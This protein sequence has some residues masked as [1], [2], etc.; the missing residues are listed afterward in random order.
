MDDFFKWFVLGVLVVYG[1]ASGYL[2]YFFSKRMALANR[3]EDR[4]ETQ[5]I[6]AIK[7]VVAIQHR[8]EEINLDTSQVTDLKRECNYRKDALVKLQTQVNQLA[9]STPEK[10]IEYK[11]DE[12]QLRE[13]VKAAILAND[14]RFR[15]LVDEE[16]AEAK[17]K[18]PLKKKP[19]A[20]RA[21]PDEPTEPA[22]PDDLFTEDLGEP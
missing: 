9:A 21:I 22:T 2:F 16:I 14:D 13:L 17:T 6:S 15:V 1:V 12:P 7:Q 8:L 19:L 4:I 20:L 3:Y 5:L 10:V 18:I 11:L